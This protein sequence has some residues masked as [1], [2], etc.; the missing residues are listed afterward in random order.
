MALQSINPT[1]TQAWKKLQ[2]HF[3]TMKNVQMQHLFANEPARAEKMNLQW[4]DFLVDYSKNIIS[5]ETIYLL[6]ELANE[7]Q[8]KTPLQNIL[9]EMGSIKPKTEPF[10]ILRYALKKMLLYK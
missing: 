5:D 1:Q 3:E 2:A 9:M 4:N 7:V 6:Q 8:L 10:Y